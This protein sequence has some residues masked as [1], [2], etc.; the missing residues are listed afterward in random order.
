MLLGNRR[1]FTGALVCA[2]GVA[3]LPVCL[4]QDAPPMLMR[5]GMVKLKS[6]GLYDWQEA[7]KLA[8][9]AYQKAGVPFRQVF[10]MAIFGE[11][12]MGVTV[13]P[14][15][16]M[17]QFD[18]DSPMTKLPDAERTKYATLMRNSI[19]SARYSLVQ[20]LPALSIRSGRKDQPKFLRVT[21]VRVLP[22]K[23]LEFEE[24]I[25]TVGLP[26]AKKAGIKD[27]WVNRSVLGTAVSEYTLLQAFDKWAEMDAWPVG[28]KLYGGAAAYKDFLARIAQTAASA[29][30]MVVRYEADLSY[31]TQP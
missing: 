17:A 3:G 20:T 15:T 6:G 7:N 18:S 5:I 28:E 22:G 14:V 16:N 21:M 11:A 30:T 9:T 10:S 29:E 24:L 26:A 31:S 27:Y 13:A 23:N 2:L 1:L 19:E 8:R 12:G 4:G 25:R